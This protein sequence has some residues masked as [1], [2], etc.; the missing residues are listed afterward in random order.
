MVE[1]ADPWEPELS[2]EAR[3]RF[4]RWIVEPDTARL[5]QRR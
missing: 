4:A 1:V 3:E 5:T 2:A